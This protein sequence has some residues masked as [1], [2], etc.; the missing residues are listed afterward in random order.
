MSFRVR[1]K[2]RIRF[3]LFERLFRQISVLRGASRLGGGGCYDTLAER[4]GECIRCFTLTLSYILFSVISS[5]CR[6][7]SHTRKVFVECLL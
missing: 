4:Y 5:R 1:L 3:P 2:Q 7:V 6:V